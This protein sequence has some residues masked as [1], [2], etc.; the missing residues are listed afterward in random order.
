[1]TDD[2]GVNWWTAERMHDVIALHVDLETRTDGRSKRFYNRDSLRRVFPRPH[3]LHAWE[4]LIAPVSDHSLA[5]GTAA[6]R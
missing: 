3:V 2:L 4:S 5:P 6:S 1:M